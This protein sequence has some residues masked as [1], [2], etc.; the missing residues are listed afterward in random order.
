MDIKAQLKNLIKEAEIYQS[1]GLLNE[2]K[3][4]FRAATDLVRSRSEMQD[5]QELIQSI[6]QRVV[7]LNQEIK[8]I[9]EA[10]SKPM[11]SERKQDLIKTLFASSGTGDADQAA[12]EGAIT[13]A[14]FGQYERAVREF[15]S[16]L[17]N[18]AIRVTAAKNI[19]RCLM[20]TGEAHRAAAVFEEWR[21]D[22]RFRPAQLEKIRFF[23][24]QRFRKAGLE[25][26]PPEEA[27]HPEID[28]A[29]EETLPVADPGVSDRP[30]V[31][32]LA[33][34]PDELASDEDVLDISSIGLRFD[35]G[36]LEGQ[37]FEL[38]VSFQSGNNLNLIVPQTEAGLIECLEKGTRLENIQFFSPIAILN[39]SGV[40]TAKN[41][42]PS[43]PKEGNFSLDLAILK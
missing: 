6:V 13:L 26:I 14:K 24:N 16:L 5:G 8:A 28:A 1:Q 15:E 31:D 41:R 10:I 17:D 19:V 29:P 18:P 22:D 20:E 38:D 33:V 23:C 7:R 39:G 43:G 40:I 37:S 11:V 12:L 27:A 9:N 3:E 34:D 2:A 35:S 32:A 30:P 36:P 21:E 42:I 25:P 4:R